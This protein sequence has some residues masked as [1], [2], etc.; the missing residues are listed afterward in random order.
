[1]SYKEKKNLMILD[2]VEAILSVIAIIVLLVASI[3]VKNEMRYLF[4][5][6]Y[7]HVGY[8]LVKNVESIIKYVKDNKKSIISKSKIS[9]GIE[10]I[11]L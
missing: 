6:L 11:S 9:N 3:I 2:V 5:F 4:L 1:M 8:N 7:V 10:N